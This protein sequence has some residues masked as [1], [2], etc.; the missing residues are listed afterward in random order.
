MC[1]C[2]VNRI[3]NKVTISLQ[4]ESRNQLFRKTDKLKIFGNYTKNG[5]CTQEIKEILYFGNVCYSAIIL[6]FQKQKDM[7]HIYSLRT[8]LRM[9]SFQV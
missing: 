7:T 2:M 8:W 1:S 4:H 9:V 6:T 3:K 5:L